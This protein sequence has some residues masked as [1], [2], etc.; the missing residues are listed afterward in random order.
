M[1]DRMT[2]TE[3]VVLLN[4]CPVQHGQMWRHAKTGD[5]Y[6][7]LDIGLEATNGRPRTIVV[8]YQ[9]AEGAHCCNVRDLVEFVAKFNK[10]GT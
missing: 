5:L 9:K 4:A 6:E 2:K 3:E 8:I 1:S 10:E 7:V